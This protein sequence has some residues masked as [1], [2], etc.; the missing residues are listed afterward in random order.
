MNVYLAKVMAGGLGLFVGVSSP[1]SCQDA[2][3]LKDRIGKLI[4]QLGDSSYGRRQNAKTELERIGVVALDQLHA[5]SF[6]VDPQI[7]A[8][9]RFIVQSNQF[10]WEW[11]YDSP[12]VREILSNYGS[13]AV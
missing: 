9:A 13:R 5:A 12:R 11:E 3:P 7:A 2:S 6:H 4:E 1:G 8:A 10:N